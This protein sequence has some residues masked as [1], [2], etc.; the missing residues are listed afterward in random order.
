MLQTV[1][2]VT[3]LAFILSC[4]Y[5]I[6][7]TLHNFES[8]TVNFHTAKCNTWDTESLFTKPGTFGCSLRSS[9]DNSLSYVGHVANL[10]NIIS[11]SLKVQNNR[12]SFSYNETELP[13]HFIQYDVSLY[14][15]F[16]DAGC[17]ADSTN[18][19][20]KWKTVL[21]LTDQFVAYPDFI[22]PDGSNA[23]LIL[24]GNLFQNQEAL[25]VKGI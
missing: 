19:L 11:V 10:T 6:T 1:L 13:K 8:G 4:A 9:S 2:L 24:F 16:S 5:D 3:Y 7:T 21:M 14:A 25:P 23:D 22:V 17:S 12:T 18:E 20:Y 15:C